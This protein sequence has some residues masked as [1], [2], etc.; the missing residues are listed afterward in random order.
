MDCAFYPISERRL[1]A[2]AD[3]VRDRIG[4][5]IRKPFLC[6]FAMALLSVPAIARGQQSAI[7]DEYEIKSALIYKLSFFM[8]WPATAY[9]NENSPIILYILGKDPFGARI[10][11]TI[12]N[13][14]VNG[15]PILVKRAQELDALEKCHILFI[16]E[17]E[18]GH[19]EEIFS[20]VQAWN[21]LTVS[22][23]QGFANAGGGINFFQENNT[24]RF[25]VNVAAIRRVHLRID[26]QVLELKQVKVILEDNISKGKNA[27]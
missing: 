26:S 14:T 19:L 22:E 7:Y 12:K 1:S 11:K 15:R 10:E 5:S 21:V 18:K 25:E 2:V 16:A 27:E 4:F 24:I 3:L 23:F 13:T 20:H 9:A 6:L 17:S 8:E